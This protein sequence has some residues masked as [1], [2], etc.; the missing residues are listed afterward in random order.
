MRQKIQSAAIA[1]GVI[2]V[3]VAAFRLTTTVPR[4]YHYHGPVI[5]IFDFVGSAVVYVMLAI[6]LGSGFYFL[7]L[8]YMSWRKEPPHTF[9]E[10]ASLIWLT[11]FLGAIGL[12][13]A[14]A[15]VAW[16]IEPFAPSISGRIWD[17]H[18]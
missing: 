5:F 1:V 18:L 2:V 12:A 16:V 11:V 4:Q 7:W 17:L 14:V 9:R 3:A 6:F 10:T 13:F 15:A 8:L